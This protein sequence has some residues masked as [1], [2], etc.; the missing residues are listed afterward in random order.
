[1]KKK[2]GILLY[3]DNDALR[4]AKQDSKELFSIMEDL[5]TIAE[6]YVQVNVVTDYAKFFNNP[7]SYMI[8]AYADIWNENLLV[9]SNIDVSSV[10]SLKERFDKLYN[11]L[12]QWNSA[13]IITK[14]AIATGVKPK[15]FDL[16]CKPEKEY[17]Y[18]VLCNFIEATRMFEEHFPTQSRKQITRFTDN[19][20]SK[21]LHPQYHLFAEFIDR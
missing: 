21:D 20:L 8:K 17:E 11:E 3:R 18:R 5:L 16:Y 2:K 1:M 19:L 10:Q 15:N 14:D 6:A 13:P 4:Y 7:L 9:A 12:D